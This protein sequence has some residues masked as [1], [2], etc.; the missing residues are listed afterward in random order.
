VKATL[1]PPEMIALCESIPARTPSRS[2]IAISLD[3][4]DGKK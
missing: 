1:F 2:F 4:A 3:L